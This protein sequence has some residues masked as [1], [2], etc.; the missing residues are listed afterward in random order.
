[1]GLLSDVEAPFFPSIRGRDS[2]A[3]LVALSVDSF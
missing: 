3:G 2:S 1:M